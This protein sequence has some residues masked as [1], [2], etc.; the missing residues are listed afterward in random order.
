MDVLRRYRKQMMFH[1]ANLWSQVRIREL[2][3]P[4]GAI[5]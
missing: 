1:W 5:C 2:D 4:G 3:R